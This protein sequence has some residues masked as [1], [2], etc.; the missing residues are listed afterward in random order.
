MKRSIMMLVALLLSPVTLAA[1]S[2]DIPYEKYVLDNGLTLI[3]HEDHKA[4]VVAVNVWYHVGS[5]NEKD[6][7]TGFAHLF[8]H[9]MFN[10]S[11]NFNDDFFK[12]LD[13]LGAT[14]I[15]GTTNFD[16]TNYF[17][18]V[19]K[20]ALES[21]LWLESDRMGHMLGAVSQERL[22]EQRGVVQN[23]K[24]QGENQ[25]YGKALITIFENMYPKGHPYSHSV[26]G[27]MDDLDAASL[28]DVHEWFKR[29]YGPSNAVL[30]IAGDVE[31]QAVKQKV[32]QYF[33]H[34]PPGPPLIKPAALPMPRNND[35]RIVMQDRVPQ[36]R[37]YKVWN[38]GKMT[39][40][41]T[42][43]LTLAGDILSNGK[44]SRLYKL[45]VYGM[46]VATDV[47]AFAYGLELGGLFGIIATAAPGEDLAALEKVIDEEVRNLIRRGPDNDELERAQTTQRAQFLRGIERVGGFGG[48]SDQ[49]AASEVYYGS[50]DGWRDSFQRLVNADDDDVQGAAERWLSKGTL[51]LEVHPFPEFATTGGGVD[52][53]KGMPEPAS[54]PEGKFPEVETTTLKN[55]LKVMLAQR[56]AVP[57][58]EMS[59]LVD[60]GHAADQFAIPGV[61]SLAMA[62]LDEGTR[63]RSSLEI[64]DE[65][66]EL[67]ATLSAGSDLDVSTVSMS[68]LTANLQ[69][70][71]ELFADVVL[72]PAFP[73][74]EFERLKQ[75]QLAS[76]QR[77]KVQPVSMALRV[78]PKLLYGDDH[79]YSNPLTGSGTQESVQ[80]MTREQLQEFHASWFKPNN[81]TLIVIGDI[82]MQELLPRVEKAFDDWKAGDVPEKNLAVVELQEKPMVYIVD[83]PDAEQSIIFASH[84]M[85]PKNNDDE[86]SI[87]AMVDVLGGSFTS[88]LNMNLR[89]DKHWSYGAGAFMYDAE[90]QRPFIAYAPVQSDKT[91]ES[92]AEILGELRGISGRQPVTAAELS[93]IKDK[94]ILT[95]PGRWETNSSVRSDLL[96]QVQF[97]LP[98]D[99]W[100]S[101]GSE[102]RNLAL[103]D[104][105]AAG[106]GYVLPGTLI[107]VVVGDRASIEAPIRKL[108]IGDIR[109]LDADGN[110]VE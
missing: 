83:R 17:E 33:G 110:P 100:S 102:V 38:I 84:V 73:A 11:E 82:S 29:Y 107:W 43:Y 35:A 25:P 59:L 103:D 1:E 98:E 47:S 90:A 14:G 8:E 55:G 31:A 36:A 56:D 92:M 9:L 49:L 65:L 16:R 24:R 48:K 13:K 3:V 28:D 95:L 86:F 64:S 37:I 89:E 27:S 5:K 66:I 4:P 54:F 93:R 51:T 68:S 106:A 42:D 94:S 63:S 96:T 104:V 105:R 22:D 58:V 81:A 7:K 26:I 40:A 77:E 78:M 71:F 72:N 61:S 97:N 70:S 41:D 109:I 12:A 23:E 91:A 18:V 80:A 79:A 50:P 39:D 75:Q 108:G 62:M 30:V 76:I 67:G 53:N 20:T 87:D 34:I 6:G 2:I 57:L 21:V 44:S 45:L 52:R 15:N 85:P 74:A 19:P 69:D 99:Y 10:G 88:R 101:Y 60:A 32:E 46:Q